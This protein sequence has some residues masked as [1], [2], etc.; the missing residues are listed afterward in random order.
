MPLELTAVAID[1]TSPARF[2][3]SELTLP[4]GITARYRPG[5]SDERVLR[6]VVIKAT[7]RRPT[8]GFDVRPGEVWL[9]LGANIGAFALYCKTNRASAVCYEPDPDCFALLAMNVPDFERHNV[10]I[11]ARHDDA[12][13]FWVGKSPSDHYRATVI[14][15]ATLPRHKNGVLPNRHASCLLNRR[16]DGVKIDI[17]GSEGE[18]LDHE[19]IPQCQKLCLEY[20]LSRDN[21]VEHLERRLRYL[22]RRFRQVRYGAELDRLIAAGVPAKTYCDRLIHCLDPRT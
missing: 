4:Y 18:L 2:A 20:H 10:A 5:T 14:P 7:Y 19:L 15:S 12:L 3:I 6:E 8:L 16:F 1:R 13:P 9:D 22:R 11:T 21:S 17:E